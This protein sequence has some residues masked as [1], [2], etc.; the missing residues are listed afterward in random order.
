MR[1]RRIAV[2]VMAV[3]ASVSGQELKDLRPLPRT[4]A[5]CEQ[6]NRIYERA[7]LEDVRQVARI[8]NSV[9]PPVAAAIVRANM[10]AELDQVGA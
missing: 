7:D 10:D 6:D 9:P 4:W 8:G 2:V 5:W 3:A 1:A